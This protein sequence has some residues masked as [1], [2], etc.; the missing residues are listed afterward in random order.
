MIKG[1]TRDISHLSFS[2]PFCTSYGTLISKVKKHCPGETVE[3]D[4]GLE[5]RQP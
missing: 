1:I 2:G 5:N 4:T 3:T